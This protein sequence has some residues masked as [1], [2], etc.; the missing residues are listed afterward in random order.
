[1]THDFE[2]TWL[3]DDPLTGVNDEELFGRTHL[4]DRIFEVLQRVSEQ[5]PS[6]IL[7]LIGSWGSGKSSILAAI[8]HRLRTKD[9][10]TLGTLGKE[11][12][13]S[14][15]NPWLYAGPAEMHDGFFDT[16]QSAFPSTGLWEPRRE[17][18][19]KLGRRLAP[20][21][22]LLQ[23]V[24]IDGEKLVTTL[25]DD[26]EESA[27]AQRNRVEK[28]LADAGQPILV[29][30]DDL[31]RLS[32]DEL[33]HLFKLVRLVGRLPNV[34]YLLSYDERTLIDLLAKTDLVSAKDERRGLDYLEKIIQVRIDVPALRPYEVD[35]VFSRAITR[36]QEDHR[37]QIPRFEIERLTRVF[38]DVLSGRLSTPRAIKRVFGQVDAFYG[39][40]REEV[41]F[42][43]YVIITWLRTVEPGVYALIQRHRRELLGHREIS[44]RFLDAPD[45]VAGQRRLEWMTMLADAHVHEAEREDVLYLLTVL[46]PAFGSTYRNE[47]EKEQRSTHVPEP[48]QGAI[49]HPDYFDRFFTFGVPAD[50]ISDAEASA[51]ARDIARGYFRSPS[52][53]AL[54]NMFDMQP[55]LVLRKL[56]YVAEAEGLRTAQLVMWLQ[57]RWS[58]LDERSFLRS[59][60]ETLAEATLLRMT[61]DHAFQVCVSRAQEPAGLLFISAVV[62]GLSMEGPGSP[63]FRDRRAALASRVMRA[64]VDM[65]SAHFTPLVGSCKSPLDLVAE[66]RAILWYW[67]YRAEES[68]TTFLLKAIDEGWELV[69]CMALFVYLSLEEDGQTYITRYDN[70]GQFTMLFD[71]AFLQEHLGDRI[72]EMVDLSA[73]R[74]VP[75]TRDVLR[76]YVL[77]GVRLAA[78]GARTPDG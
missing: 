20:I 32:A 9:E 70:P 2:S 46:F 38:D 61:D 15:F 43:D 14:E 62:N 19:V 3:S 57:E 75:A 5:S 77:S 52:A 22:G 49:S 76:A 66:D 33:L 1:M 55:E 21:A 53:V 74:G 50:D 10:A 56:S 65:Y 54:V 25:L 30:I 16:L 71:P 63:E 35:R 47:T 36:L 42:T 44:L 41:N 27:V 68:L 26:A 69:D 7:G 39:A 28:E 34:Y 45:R 48:Q 59:R 64:L 6:S 37:F 17:N 67:R 11:W 18:L 31:D 73:L 58:A 29:I 4:A 60:V 40:T 78:N 12:F 24:R 72:P 13:V 23:A 8:A 51:A